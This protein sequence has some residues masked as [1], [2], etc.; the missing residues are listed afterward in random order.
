MKTYFALLG[1]ALCMSASSYAQTEKV[2]PSEIKSVTVYK[3]GAQIEREARVSLATGQTLVKLTGLSPYINKES[4]R[5]AGDGSF[6]I[7]SVQHQNDFLNELGRSAEM[8][9]LTQKMESLRS[10]I[11]EEET[12]VKIISGKLD[13]LQANKAVAGKEQTI[14]PEAFKSLNTIYGANVEQL[15]LDLLAR[16]RNI[17]AHNKELDK[18]RNQQATLNNRSDLP[19]GTL[20][21]TVDSRSASPVRL[22][23]SYRVANASWSPSYDMRFMG[24]DKPLK[25][26]HK[27]NISQNTGVDWKDVNLVLSTAQTDVSATLPVLMPLYM[28]FYDANLRKALSGRMP[29]MEVQEMAMFEAAPQVR[30][31]GL[32]SID[33]N[34]PLYIVD[35]VPRNDISDLDPN[36]ISSIQVLKDA[37][38]TAVYGSRAVNGV[39]VVTTKRGGEDLSV[40][41][42]ITARGE[43]S[44]A[45]MVE[46]L[47]TVASNNKATIVAYKEAELKADFAYQAVPKLAPHVFL[48]GKIGDWYQADLLNGE[49]NIYLENAYVGHTYIDT[50]AYS[51]TLELSFGVDNNLSI[52]REKMTEFSENQFIGSNRKE[53]LAFKLS[54][55]NNKSYP[56]EVEVFDQLP[57]STLKEIQ[58]EALE[59]SSAQWDA[60]SGKLLWKVKLNPNASRDLTLKYSVRYPK[61]KRVNATQ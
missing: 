15:N 53:T 1:M 9:D 50:D 6:T 14:S 7:L 49:A 38:A 34:S 42:T 22:S 27:A 12:W 35:G 28:R 57:I 2:V 44:S 8:E 13:F 54:L 39:V 18:L 11:E 45:F 41:L 32:S 43:T 17:V 5:V 16:N 52:K 20:L 59:L 36:G 51:D 46:A 56:V 61:D 4:I 25:V 21:V 10:K 47:Q 58:V 26:T 48:I 29:G 23:F 19:S 31:R 40:P 3:A 55:R 30:I 37:S 60:T 33:E 24:L